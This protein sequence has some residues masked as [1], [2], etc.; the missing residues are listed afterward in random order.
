MEEDQEEGLYFCSA[1]F[2]C[3]GSHGVILFFQLP[4]C[5]LFFHRQLFGLHVSL[6]MPSDSQGKKKSLGFRKGKNED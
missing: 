1:Q 2:L 5:L 4:N 6:F 3:Y